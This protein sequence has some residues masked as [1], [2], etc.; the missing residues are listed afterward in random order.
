MQDLHKGKTVVHAKHT[1]KIFI[2]IT[3][4]SIHNEFKIYTD[5]TSITLSCTDLG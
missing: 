3:L 5:Q 4:N 2:T 1:Q